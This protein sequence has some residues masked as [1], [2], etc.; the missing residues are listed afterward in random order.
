[1]LTPDRATI[2]VWIG[3]G[4]VIAHTHLDSYDNFFVQLHGKKRFLLFNPA[5]ATN[6]HPYPFLHP[7]HAQAQVDIQLPD[8]SFWPEMK[9]IQCIE[10]NLEP[11]DVLYLPPLWFHFVQAIDAS[12]SV[13]LW[14]VG[15]EQDTFDSMIQL[16]V[17]TMDHSWP[18]PIKRG[19]AHYVVSQVLKNIGKDLV[20]AKLVSSL[21]WERDARPDVAFV[22]EL[23]KQRYSKL[24]AAGEL[25]STISD[26][27]V[28]QFEF[29]LQEHKS[30]LSPLVRALTNAFGLGTTQEGNRHWWLGNYAE[31][32]ALWGTSTGAQAGPFLHNC[33]K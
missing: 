31:S 28:C 29:N 3:Q 16:T 15:R 24:F 4:G 10:A 21:G 17:K 12:I 11:G 33:F 22:R 9:D 2:N 8:L 7:S 19:V 23:I 13:N 32:L 30:R 1:V 5:Q 6:L 27:D 26:V 20:S 14:S 25:Q 18:Q